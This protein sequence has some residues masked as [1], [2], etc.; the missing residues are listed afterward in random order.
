MNVYLEESDW[1]KATQ[2]A[3]SLRTSNP[4]R[5]PNLQDASTTA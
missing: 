2:L 1:L 4:V 3:L 5:V